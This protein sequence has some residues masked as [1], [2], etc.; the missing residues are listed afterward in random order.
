MNSVRLFRRPS[1]ALDQATTI[2]AAMQLG[3]PG[4]T[5]KAYCRF[6]NDKRI[7]FTYSKE[8]GRVPGTGEYEIRGMIPNPPNYM[9]QSGYKSKMSVSSAAMKTTR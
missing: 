9:T 7:A 6:S 8:G 4:S 1:S 5:N 3:L 2:F